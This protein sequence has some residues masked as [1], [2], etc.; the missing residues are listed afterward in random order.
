MA[1]LT[2]LNAEFMKFN[3]VLDCLDRII[4]QTCFASKPTYLPRQQERCLTIS[5]Y[6][7]QARDHI[8][9]YLSVKS[10]PGWYKVATSCVL[11]PTIC[12]RPLFLRCVWSGLHTMLW[13]PFTLVVFKI[14]NY[15]LTCTVT[16]FILVLKFG[17][18]LIPHHHQFLYVS[19]T[20][21]YSKWLAA[22]RLWMIC[23]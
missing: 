21:G 18:F 5:L 17:R 3:G 13:C 15:M 7:R 22:P 9:I 10:M 11:L 6:F 8:A 20:Y 16:I 2:E 4:C 12:R 23:T 14:D 1:I 19:P